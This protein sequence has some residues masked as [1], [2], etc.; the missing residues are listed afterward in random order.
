[1]AAPPEARYRAVANPAGNVS[2]HRS[3]AGWDSAPVHL[4]HGSQVGYHLT[5]WWAAPRRAGLSG[6]HRVGVVRTRA[7][8][9]GRRLD[10]WRADLVCGNA[11]GSR[12][13][14]RLDT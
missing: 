4:H 8:R 5:V 1:M 2:L 13:A 11:A 12:T 3:H 14:D 10:R 7:H 9:A 6:D